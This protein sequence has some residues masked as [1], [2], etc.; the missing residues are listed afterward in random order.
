MGRQA[1]E[2]DADSTTY[3]RWGPCAS[4]SPVVERGRRECFLMRTKGWVIPEPSNSCL[5]HTRGES[6]MA[7]ITDPI[8][9]WGEPSHRPDGRAWAWGG[10]RDLFLTIPW[11]VA[12]GRGPGAQVPA[13][14]GCVSSLGSCD[15]LPPLCRRNKIWSESI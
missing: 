2:P 1:L 3:Q 10:Q 4:V 5:A 9:P 12:G 11:R 14:H 13:D 8:T 7:V 15:P 6:A